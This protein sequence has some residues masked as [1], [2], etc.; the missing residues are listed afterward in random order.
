M[1]SKTLDIDANLKALMA[2]AEKMKKAQ[3][4][5]L[6]DLVLE[7][8]VEKVL[9]ADELKDLLRWSLVQLKA[10]PQ[11]KEEW[12]RVAETGFLGRHGANGK[13]AKITSVTTRVG[14]PDLLSGTAAE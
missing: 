2:R 7:T 1:P 9:D 13:P 4:L 10:N 11:L 14:T 8:G 6:G 3:K 5:R 12:R